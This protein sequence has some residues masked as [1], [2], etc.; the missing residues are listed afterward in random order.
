MLWVCL[1]HS[2][3]VYVAFIVGGRECH[4]PHSHTQS[5][6]CIPPDREGLV[7]TN[8]D[9]KF[10]VKFILSI[11]CIEPFGAL[12]GVGGKFTPTTCICNTCITQQIIFCTD[13]AHIM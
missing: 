10:I 2:A 4:C 6:Q 13:S 1:P 7:H 5:T 8:P 9:V 11:L 3:Y 12:T